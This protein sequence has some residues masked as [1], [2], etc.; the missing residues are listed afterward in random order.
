MCFSALAS[1]LYINNK[2][3]TG[4]GVCMG[5]VVLVALSVVMTLQGVAWWLVA[6]V[7]AGFIAAV[8]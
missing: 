8:I 5:L 6:S 1:I 4:A 7:V 2:P 3:H